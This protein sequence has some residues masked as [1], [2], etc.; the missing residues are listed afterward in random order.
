MD[1][2][3]VGSGSVSGKGRAKR[4]VFAG[5]E[6]SC[7]AE[8]A[9][10]EKGAKVFDVSAVLLVEGIVDKGSGDRWCCRDIGSIIGIGVR[11]DF[12]VV[13]V[14]VSVGVGSGWVSFMN[15]DFGAIAQ[16]IAV[17]IGI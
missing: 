4:I 13:I 15:F 2:R 9:R 1:I 17:T 7:A 10:G 3:V 11:N 8:R 14:T 6:G 16:S 12:D 5:A